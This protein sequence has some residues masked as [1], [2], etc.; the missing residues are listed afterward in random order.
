MYS[1]GRVEVGGDKQETVII[2]DLF[3]L[4]YGLY[5][6]LSVS[7]TFLVLFNV[8]M[9]LLSCISLCYTYSTPET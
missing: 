8:F 2:S 7:G 1:E 3:L 6:I 4:H 9:I 5:R